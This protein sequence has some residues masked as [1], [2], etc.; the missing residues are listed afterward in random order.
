MKKRRLTAPVHDAQEVNKQLRRR[1]QTLLS[2]THR[3][4]INV[5]CV[6]TVSEQPAK[7]NLMAD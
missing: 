4:A 6:S 2:S 3:A 7:R 5:K 1:E